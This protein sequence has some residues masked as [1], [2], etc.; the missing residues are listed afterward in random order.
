[1]GAAEDVDDGRKR[2]VVALLDL[3]LAGDDI[4]QR[5]VRRIVASGE[6]SQA[7]A[8]A[9][10]RDRLGGGRP[11]LVGIHRVVAV[12]HAGREVPQA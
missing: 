10:A 2:L 8:L 4:H 9:P 7:D 1:M 11:Q 3:P 6:L 5:V 12:T